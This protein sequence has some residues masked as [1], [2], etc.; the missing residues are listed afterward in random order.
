MNGR[1]ERNSKRRWRRQR[2]RR[3]RRKKWKSSLEAVKWAVKNKRSAKTARPAPGAAAKTPVDTSA[4]LTSPYSDADSCQGPTPG[5]PSLA[6][7]SGHRAAIA[8]FAQPLSD[9]AFQGRRWSGIFVAS[10]PSEIERRYGGIPG[11]TGCCRA[12]PK[13]VSSTGPRF[14]PAISNCTALEWLGTVW[15][16]VVVVVVVIIVVVIP[17]LFLSRHKRRL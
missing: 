11:L 1:M 10:T 6:L 17:R 5:L 2:R 8:R 12:R 15:L 14:V 9:G 7:G 4:D 16:V 3:R 13:W